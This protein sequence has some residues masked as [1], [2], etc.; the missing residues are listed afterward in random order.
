[1]RLFG[2]LGGFGE[3]IGMVWKSGFSSQPS[4][5][6]NLITQKNVKNNGKI[7]NLDLQE[8]TLE[9][10][11]SLRQQQGRHGP[12]DRGEV[13]VRPC[14][15]KQLSQLPPYLIIIIII[16]ST[17]PYDPFFLQELL[18][19]PESPSEPLLKLQKIQQTR[20]TMCS[21]TLILEKTALYSTST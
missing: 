5:G 14:W 16:I 15:R 20:G 21:A 3:G 13:R 17:N 8:F 9:V 2:D 10:P 4:L 11:C 19:L 12:A 7:K 6:V 1:M 18:I